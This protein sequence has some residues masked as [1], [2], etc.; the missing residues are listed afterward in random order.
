MSRGWP[1]L[2]PRARRCRANC[3]PRRALWLLP[4]LALVVALGLGEVVLARPLLAGGAAPRP[5]AGLAL[6]AVVLAAALAELPLLAGAR[7]FGRALD[8]G[9]RRGF[10]RKLPRLG[11]RYFAS[12]PVSDMA[13]RLQLL[14]RVR[15]LPGLAVQLGRTLGELALASAAIA[16]LFPPG[17]PLALAMLLSAGVIPAVS[18]PAAAERDLRLRTHAGALLRFYL[19][20]LLGLAAVRTHGAG[21]ALAR[22][23]EERL[24][25][26]RRA[27]R[28]A[29]NTA[30]AIEAVTV[31]IT[32]TGA[33]AL[34]GG[35]LRT[36]HAA[37]GAAFLLLFLALRIPTQAAAIAGLWRQLPEHRNVALRL[38]E[39][40]GAPV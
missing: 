39:T 7:R 22:E 31:L 4:L 35:Y 3:S 25:E 1:P 38:Q 36:P 15:L 12:R 24:R 37:T 29:V 33:A 5:G 10:F 30:A 18:M 28:D 16:W 13:E 8:V 9:L 6:L 20:A 40:L 32:V 34:L 2:A 11:D 27:G 23:H 21:P 14:H 17:A 19:D 26:W